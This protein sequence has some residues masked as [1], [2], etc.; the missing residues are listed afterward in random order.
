M[1]CESDFQ[2]SALNSVGMDN[3]QISN[4][5][6]LPIRLVVISLR[7]SRKELCRRLRRYAREAVNVL[8]SRAA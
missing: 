4:A 1:L 7:R 6:K 2:I 5:L 3:D 8:V